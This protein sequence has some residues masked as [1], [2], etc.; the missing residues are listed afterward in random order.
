MP[1]GMAIKI[2]MTTA[3]TVCASVSTE[4]GHLP[5]NPINVMPLAVSKD[6]FQPA[7]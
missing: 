2:E 4:S 1:I 5:V 3:T 7:I 6:I